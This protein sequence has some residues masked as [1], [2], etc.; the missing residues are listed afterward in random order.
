[1][2]RYSEPFLTYIHWYKLFLIYAVS[3][4]L[5]L[6]SN[7]SSKPVP[8]AG[9]SRKNKGASISCE[10]PLSCISECS[11]VIANGL[12]GVK[13][14]LGLLLKPTQQQAQ[15]LLEMV[16]WASDNAPEQVGHYPSRVRTLQLP[17]TI[18][19][20]LESPG[21]LNW[22]AQGQDLI[23]S[24]AWGSKPRGTQSWGE[25]INWLVFYWVCCK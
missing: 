12:A 15:H 21:A 2:K 23:P 6:T 17:G 11:T 14:W 4:L 3:A 9:I 13:G 25:G 10:S 16:K 20:L 5:H 8:L 18:P 24:A 1:M 22:A 19:L 7:Y